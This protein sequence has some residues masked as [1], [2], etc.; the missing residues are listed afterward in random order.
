MAPEA[1]LDLMRKR[2]RESSTAIGPHLAIPHIV[3]EGID[4]FGILL[5]R[6][7]AGVYFSDASPEVNA[8]FVLVGSKDAR[9]FHLRAL[10]AIAQ[11]TQ[12]PDFEERWLS[13]RSIEGLR[14]VV[15]LGERR[16]HVP[17]S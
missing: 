12:S 16:R 7:H 4:T 1:F 2:E 6:C 14:D 15:L 17:C 8:V 10:S 11:I 3:I 5:A 9:N 13:A